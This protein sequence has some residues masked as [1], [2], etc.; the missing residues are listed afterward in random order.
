MMKDSIR[1]GYNLPPEINIR[2]EFARNKVLVFHSNVV[3]SHSSLEKFVLPSSNVQRAN[4]S[5][6]VPIT[7]NWLK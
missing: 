4:I 5:A 6:Q 1:K 7:K 3:Q 2:S